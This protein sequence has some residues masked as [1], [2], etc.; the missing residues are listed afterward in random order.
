M[1]QYNFRG[2]LEPDAKSALPAGDGLVRVDHAV[3]L[4]TSARDGD[5]TVALDIQQ[6]DLL[7]VEFDDG[8]VLWTNIERLKDDAAHTAARTADDSVFPIRY[9]IV[10]DS[11]DRGLGS[12]L[13]RAVRVLGV[14]LPKNA[15]LAAA[16]KIEDQLAGDGQFF[17]VDSTG[18]LTRENPEPAAPNAPTLVLIHGTASSTS[19]AFAGLFGTNQSIWAQIVHHYDGRVYAF[20][21]RTLTKS[22]L[23]NAVEF[24]NAMPAD[25]NL[26]L[27]T[28]SRGGLIGDLIA[29]GRVDGAVFAENDV[30]RELT[31]AYADNAGVRAD[32]QDLYA[33]FNQKMAIARPHVSRY[34]RVGC[35]AGGTTLASKRLDVY[36]SIMV[37]LL[38]KIPGVGPILGGLGELAAAVA[39]ERTKPEVLP[40]LEAQM[41]TSAFI[42][43]L[44]GS[45]HVLNSDL[46]VLAGDSDGL[47]KNL[48]NLFYWRAND[49]VVDT[50]SMYAGAQREQRLWHLEENSDVTHV[51]YFSREETALVV[52]QGLLRADQDTSGFQTRKPRRALRGQANAGL[53]GDNPEQTG[54]ILLPGMMG[55]HLDD[56]I[57]GDEKPDRIWL[58]K[59]GLMRGHGQRLKIGAANIEPSALLRSPY[60]DFRDYLIGQGL[61]VMPLAYDWRLSLS[62]AAPRLEELITQRLGASRKP[63]HI[64]AHSMGGLVA[65]LFMARHP[66]TWA[67]LRDTG[68]RLVQVGTPNRGSYVVPR[69]LQGEE[70]IIRLLASLDL[71]TDLDTWTRWVSRFDGILE[72]APVFGGPD[73]SKPATWKALRARTAPS[74]SRL[75]HADIVRGQLARQSAR[76]AAEEV[77]YVAGG[78]APT[79]VYDATTS[80]I[81]FTQRGDGRVT[82]ESG[83]P[84]GVVAW[85]VDAK[86]GSLLNAKDTFDGLAELITNGETRRLSTQRPE[87]SGTLR[88]APDEAPRLSNAEDQESEAQLIPTNESLEAAAM[89]MDER[90]RRDSNRPTAIPDCELSVVHGDLR[91]SQTPIVVGHYRGDQIVHAENALDRCLNGALRSRHQLGIYPGKIGSA[92]VV[93]RGASDAA[94]GPGPTGAIVLGLGDVGVLTPGGLTRSIQTGLLRYAQ[95]C[96]ESGADM[97]NMQIAALLVGSGESGVSVARSIESFMVAA[98]NVNRALAGLPSTTSR[99]TP[100]STTPLQRHFAS[101]EFVELYKDLALEALHALYA[102]RGRSGFSINETLTTHAG[103]RKRSRSYSQAPWWSRL[104]ITSQPNAAKANIETLEFTAYGERARASG[105]SIDIQKSLVDRLI[106]DAIKQRG[107]GDDTL[108]QT[109]FELLVPRLLKG[110]A[111]DGRDIQLILD[112]SSAAY[113]W[114]LLTDRRSQDGNS[115]SIGAGMLRQLRVG[116]IDPVTHPEDNRILVVGDPPSELPPLPGAQREAEV[117]ADLFDR[118]ASWDLTTEIRNA[119]RGREIDA[120]SIVSSLTG[121]DYR[122]LHLAGHGVYDASGLTGSGMVIGDSP[123]EDD[124]FVLINSALVENALLQPELVFINCCHL[125]R[126]ERTEVVPLQKLA[127]NLGEQFI[128]SGAK[129]VVAAGWPVDDEAATAFALEF[130]DRMLRGDDFGTA[131]TAARQR[132]RH[133]ESNTWAAYQCY[134]DPGFRLLMDSQIR[135]QVRRRSYTA[136][137]FLD[138]SEL[139]IELDNLANSTTT[140][141]TDRERASIEAKLDDLRSVAETKHWLNHSGVLAR[142]ARIYAEL[143]DFEKAIETYEE[144]AAT[145]NCDV[146]LNDIERLINL[147][148]RLGAQSKNR[149]LVASALDDL[150]ALIKQ[151][152]DTSERHSLMGSAYKRMA[153]LLTDPTDIRKNVRRSAEHY[154]KAADMT[155]TN[156][157]YPATNALLAILLL[158]GPWDEAPSARTNVGKLY[159]AVSWAKRDVF[160]DRLS[161]LA[162]NLSAGEQKTFWDCAANAGLDVVRAFA[163]KCLDAQKEPLLE[164][165]L[166]ITRMVGSDRE[167]ASIADQWKYAQH[168][169]TQIGSPTDAGAFDVLHAGLRELLKQKDETAT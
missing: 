66:Q 73:F 49:L 76:M 87:A 116:D 14:D 44:N 72:M 61:H 55:S 115:L 16:A 129:A 86:H 126:I 81:R 17:R 117:V 50:R 38:G 83:I 107:N 21:H 157:Y 96:M 154:V 161:R 109:L 112:S 148:V 70:E 168:V 28:H 80:E 74:E 156:W 160:S 164:R 111:S 89:M 136:G 53:P 135:T 19:N 137:D 2:T 100:D 133:H 41:P 123:L 97:A 127:A 58:D 11:N 12:N 130:Y 31:H 149:E 46:T 8:F 43:L 65:S 78:P 114:E 120:S 134:G 32:Q 20:E 42:R 26:H 22:P 159:N 104:Q 141:K 91:F 105:A 57:G 103:G 64:V 51:N 162:A 4:A 165:Y 34:V 110:G 140:A 69:M 118:R 142:M 139:R 15:A 99:Q 23:E 18:T 63:L 82:W 7:E 75:H 169:S 25:A 47:F 60:D 167:I 68:G 144:A 145:D 94:A 124:P 147:R 30:A 132:V 158:E 90:P 27:V 39:K 150:E 9:P 113:P 5:Q 95:A 45:R 29:H 108:R 48:A 93:L 88:S 67:R 101:I 166:T 35:P 56:V 155:D 54:V 10:E 92:E 163:G 121:S 146:T 128:R 138:V 37:N 102:L 52:R 131:V 85:Y 59:F 125:G 119:N 3:Q 40:G 143:K 33:R 24:L 122:I 79:P 152:G 98:A 62:H 1:S 77:L 71:R 84:S 106:R 151:Y 36:V 153:L 6:D 13:I